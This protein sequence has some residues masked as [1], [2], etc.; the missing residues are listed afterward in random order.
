MKIVA[1]SSAILDFLDGIIEDPYA[2]IRPYRL[3]L[4]SPVA[5]HEVLRAYPQN[6]HD[7]L[8][9]KLSNELLPVPSLEHWTESARVL[10]ALYPLRQQRSVARMQN[11][12][13]IAL[14]AREVDAP[15]WS[16]DRDFVLV[17]NHL[18]VGLFEE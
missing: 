14:A 12:V 15:I 6:L 8:F 1:D 7:P 9:D 13:L 17:C 10:R 16:R 5:L 2:V 3:I 11:D 18:D 4:I